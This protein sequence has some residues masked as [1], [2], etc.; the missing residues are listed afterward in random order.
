[1]FTANMYLIALKSRL[2]QGLFLYH[3]RDS[4]LKLNLILN[5]AC[6]V[7][8]PVLLTLA[9]CLYLLNCA[10][11]TLLHQVTAKVILTRDT[12]NSSLIVVL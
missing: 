5:L 4:Y 8:Y 12:C 11:D 7:I 3:R 9:I 1:M 2:P 6:I 10:I